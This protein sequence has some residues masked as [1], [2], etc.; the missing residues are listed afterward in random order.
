MTSPN[1]GAVGAP[2]GLLRGQLASPAPVRG[3]RAVRIYMQWRSKPAFADVPKFSGRLGLFEGGADA[4]DMRFEDDL[5]FKGAF[6]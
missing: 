5:G 2:I 1:C 3:S 6:V 4:V